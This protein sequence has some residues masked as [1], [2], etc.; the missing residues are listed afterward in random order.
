VIRTNDIAGV[1]PG[2]QPVNLVGDPLA[3]ANQTFSAGNGN[4]QNFWFNPQAFADPAA[5][6]FGNAA[7]N[8]LYN[9]GQQQWDIALFKNFGTGA[10]GLVLA[11]APA[12]ISGAPGL[13]SAPQAA[14]PP[15]PAA[16]AATSSA[17]ES[18]TES[19]PGTVVRFDMVAVP[20]GT[21]T[22]GSPAGEPGRSDDEG[23]QVTVKVG[24]FWMG[25]LEVTWAEFDLY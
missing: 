13:L 23:P 9:P 19:I 22:M 1:G 3:N 20:G 2:N 8:L 21:T 5:G 25:R 18:Y 4:D 7:R 24:P 10:V 11:A 15:A 14:N 16:P 17:F 12:R 6:T